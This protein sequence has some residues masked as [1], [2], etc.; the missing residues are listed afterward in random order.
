MRSRVSVPTSDIWHL[1]S[2]DLTCHHHIS[3]SSVF[4]FYSFSIFPSPTPP[5]PCPTLPRNSIL[6]APPQAPMPPPKAQGISTPLVLKAF[7]NRRRIPLPEMGF[8]TPSPPAPSPA[9]THAL[10]GASRA[11]Q[12]SA[13]TAR[14][15]HVSGSP[16]WRDGIWKRVP[17]GSGLLTRRLQF[18]RCDGRTVIRRFQPGVTRPDATQ[19]RGS[20]GHRGS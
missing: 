2:D 15:S 6:G 17:L 20:A 1:T 14:R 12:P 16:A 7:H 4:F 9:S 3:I 18:P 8:V 10:L 19:G 13:R 5:F 11:P